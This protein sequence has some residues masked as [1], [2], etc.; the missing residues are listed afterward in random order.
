MEFSSKDP[1]PEPCSKNTPKF[2]LILGKNKHI[3]EVFFK[4]WKIHIHKYIHIYLCT[5]CIPGTQG[6]QKNATDL[7][8]KALEVVLSHLMW[9]LVFKHGYPTAALLLRQIPDSQIR[10]CSAEDEDVPGLLLLSLA[11]WR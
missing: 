10:H 7:Q 11:S 3:N 5:I 6:S 4:L 9:A 2:I 8:D 1:F